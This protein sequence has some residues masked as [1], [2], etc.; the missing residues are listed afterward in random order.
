MSKQFYKSK[1]SIATLISLFS[2]EPEK[3]YEQLIDSGHYY[4]SRDASTFWTEFKQLDIDRL[5][6][7]FP[8]AK[9]TF[10]KVVCLKI[11]YDLNEFYKIEKETCFNEIKTLNPT[12][13]DLVK[14]F[15]LCLELG[16]TN[17]QGSKFPCYS[18]ESLKAIKHLLKEI[19]QKPNT[20]GQSGYSVTLVNISNKLLR[21]Q[22]DIEFLGDFLDAI[23]WGGFEMNDTG[24]KKGYLITIP[25]GQTKSKNLF[26]LN[27]LK[28][29][30][31]RNYKRITAHPEISKEDHFLK[32]DPKWKTQ[33]GIVG[34]I[35]NS[36]GK[37]TEHRPGLTSIQ[38]N[39]ELFINL[40]SE[41]PL[42]RN[43]AFQELFLVQ[44]EQNFHFQFRQA[45]S[46]IYFP[47]DEVDI[48]AL[49]LQIEPN[50]LVTLYQ[51]ICAQSCL[52][53]IADSF[54]TS[55]EFP[56]GA[57]INTFKKNCLL[58]LQNKGGELT[59]DANE[60][61]DDQIVNNFIE[62]EKHYNGNIFN[63]ITEDI[64][65]SLFARIEGLHEC[66]KDEMLAMIKLFSGLETK[67]P[68][69]SIYKAE[70]TYYFS[71]A[72]CCKFDL[73]RNLYNNYI[74]D[75]LFNSQSQ[76]KPL[77]SK[78]DE[79]HKSREF[80]FTNS[81][82]DLFM[83][84]TPFV[85][86]GLDYG[87]PKLKYDFGDLKGEFDVIAYFQHENV[88]IPIQVKLS[89]VSPRT[90]KRK[91]LW[92]ASNIK[93]SAI[94][95]V[96]KDFKL[97]KNEAGLKF[98]ADNF[99]INEGIVNPTIYPLIVTDNFFADHLSFAYNDGGDMVY[100]ISYFELKQLLLN[101]IIHVNQDALPKLSNN[102]FCSDL[103]MAIE[104]NIFWNFLSDDANK[105]V[106]RKPSAL[107][108]INDEYVIEMKV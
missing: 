92:V 97:L 108:A 44:Q 91:K 77:N 62:I 14:A 64:L 105:F 50:I 4:A 82:K 85:A 76:Q 7:L 41:D 58:H 57:N 99:N 66:T 36:S 65:I 79:T 8:D 31:K 43:L 84:F 72:T 88:V 104:S 21:L 30:Y 59:S 18:E 87:N 19:F 42:Q 73:N 13:K 80:Q 47:N 60:Y 55:S 16:E 83:K 32:N 5:K 26:I 12:Q 67:I 25:A 56:N 54:R 63:F 28:N 101:E 1:P 49:H 11:F 94:L 35:H 40:K 29:K 37:I 3:A 48:H 15:F 27:E 10:D 22:L 71:Y 2:K 46:Q 102:A 106:F 39:D 98:I 23:I 38:Y 53:A 89:N 96:K 9:A 93:K 61:C 20:V 33:E 17:P 103:R 51:L 24:N 86:S 34:V 81:L 45:L 74:S 70:D 68:F 95:Q 90:E 78:I 69:N 6:Q 107:T 100:C 52:I 75:K